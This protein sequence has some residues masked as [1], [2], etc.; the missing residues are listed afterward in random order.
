M[1]KIHFIVNPIAGRGEAIFD[2]ETLSGYFEPERYELT[3][4]TSNYSGHATVLTKES[5]ESG[6]NIIVAC[7]GDGTINEVASC[8]VHTKVLLGIIPMGSGNG[9][10]ESLD[11]SRNVKRAV[12]IIKSGKINRIDVA[13]VN[14]R[15]FFSN[16]G[17][18]FDATVISNYNASQHRRFW[19]YLK[20][21][22]K[23]I[24]DFKYSEKINVEM[25]GKSFKTRPFMF[26]ISNSKVMGYDISLTRMA[27]LQ[28][29]LLDVVIIDDLNKVQM[30]IL[31]LFIL[32]R[33]DQ[34][35]KKIQHYKVKHLKLAFEDMQNEHL[36]QADGELHNLIDR[37]IFVNVKERA[38][39]VLCP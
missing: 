15:P 12:E 2:K 10:A 28:D 31:G 13:M 9:L 18:G 37:E 5:L 26:F 23:S 8:L 6:A 32:L 3:V 14:G 25:N 16:M 4:K 24:K 36:M 39:H 7:G 22:I 21:V 1:S 17:I 34:Y 11:I 19:A 20:A 33:L 27:S 29:G 30:L 38:L 35:L